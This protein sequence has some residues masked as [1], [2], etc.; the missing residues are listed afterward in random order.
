MD[1]QTGAAMSWYVV[2]TN[3]KC[4]RKAA[5]WLRRAGLRVWVPK[6]MDVHQRHATGETIMRHRPLWCG[7]LLVRFP[8]SAVSR[9]VPRFGDARAC[10]GVADFLRW[11][12][13]RG[14]EPVPLADALVGEYMRR[15]RRHDYDGARLAVAERAARRAR[16]L[17]ARQVRIKD[18]PM[19]R[20]LARIDHLDASTAWLLVDIFGRQTPVAVRGAEDRLEPADEPLARRRAAA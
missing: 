7:L 17:E 12:T 9:G 3:P 20:F 2:R 4:E 13:A 14:L 5:M 11:S 18:G 19:A 8:P 1:G 10:F 6:R 16:L 15:Q